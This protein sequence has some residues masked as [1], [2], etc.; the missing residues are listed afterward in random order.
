MS[1]DK[2]FA[3]FATRTAKVTGSPWTFG[4]CLALV[5][6]WAASGPVFGFSETWQLVI[7]TGT[8]IVTFLMVFLIQN[9]QNRDGEAIQAKLDDLI[10]TSEAENAFI[11][12][13]KLSDKELRAL[14]QRCLAR[15][16]AHESAHARVQAEM[17]RRNGAGGGE[18]KAAPRAKA[19]GPKARGRRA[20]A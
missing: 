7:N 11:G 15:A 10:L 18:R 9:T 20:A 6:A 14:H 16:R 8:T 19:A 17:G 13:E 3:A 2:A 12:I 5:L 1:L 4:A